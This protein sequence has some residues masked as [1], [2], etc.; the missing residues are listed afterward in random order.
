[1]LL[2]NPYE[3]NTTLYDPKV[4]FRY[5]QMKCVCALCWSL[6]S[7]LLIFSAGMPV[8]KTLVRIYICYRIPLS[9][10]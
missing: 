5:R 3:T 1:M 9:L 2:E 10:W 6:I 7:S 4:S 8:E